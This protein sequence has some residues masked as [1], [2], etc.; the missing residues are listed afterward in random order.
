MRTTKRFK[1]PDSNVSRTPQ[2][3][4]VKLVKQAQ[5]SEPV[6]D[7]GKG[8]TTPAEN[9][10]VVEKLEKVTKDLELNPK[11]KNVA[12]PKVLEAWVNE[13]LLEVERVEHS[14]QNI[15]WERKQP[16]RRFGLDRQS[17]EVKFRNFY[18]SNP[19]RDME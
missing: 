14:D 13:T 8:T 7:E 1:T 5:S 17:L 12:N 15:P 16:L 10:M 11:E 9:K 3:N 18:L 4:Q 6:V 2:M 19:P